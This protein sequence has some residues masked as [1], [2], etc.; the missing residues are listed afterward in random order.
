VDA[1]VFLVEVEC[2][3]G[4]EIAVADEGSEFEDCL[5]SGQAPAGAGDV[6]SVFDDV[7]AGAFDA[8]AMGQP[9]VRAVG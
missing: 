6:E 1:L 5:G 8:V 2:P 7:A 3:V 9:A 4:V